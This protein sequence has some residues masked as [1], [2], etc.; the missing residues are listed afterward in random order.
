MRE[1]LYSVEIRMREVGGGVWK[2]TDRTPLNKV[3]SEQW[4]RGDDEDLPGCT[5]F[6]GLLTSQ[7]GPGRSSYSLGLGRT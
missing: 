7:L 4:K 2:G 3:M 5:V 1:K 6:T